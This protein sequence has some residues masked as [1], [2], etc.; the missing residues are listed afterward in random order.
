MDILER[1][2]L[3]RKLLDLFSQDLSGPVLDLACGPGQVAGYLQRKGLDVRG[4]DLSER[5]VEL[6][7][8][9]FP[10]VDFEVGDLLHLGESE[11]F[12]ALTAFYAVVHLSDRHIQRAFHEMFAA[13]R[14]GG[15]LLVTFHSELLQGNPEYRILPMEKMKAALRQAGFGVEIEI[16]RMP[17]ADEDRTRRGLLWVRK[18]A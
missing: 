10:E 8:E 7:R 3:D 15:R 6:A 14:T 9:N 4:L 5:M 11:S 1:T 12:D 13:L 16:E 18:P 2:P 17:V